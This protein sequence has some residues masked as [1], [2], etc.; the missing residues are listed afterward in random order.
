MTEEA[1]FFCGK[2]GYIF[3]STIFL[4]QHHAELW[5]KHHNHVFAEQL[6]I[7]ITITDEDWEREFKIF[8]ERILN[9]TPEK[10]QF[11]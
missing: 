7:H 1:C 6:K 5:Q 3:S 11:T 8:A 2:K 4:C 10:V 9:T